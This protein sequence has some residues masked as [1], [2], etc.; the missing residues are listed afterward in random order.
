MEFVQKFDELVAELGPV[1]NVIPTHKPYHANKVLPRK[2]I[3]AVV[4]GN[5]LTRQ[6]DHNSMKRQVEII[7]RAIS[8]PSTTTAEYR[9]DRHSL[10]LHNNRRELGNVINNEASTAKMALSV[11]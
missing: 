2:M 4:G 7:Q 3:K 5:P 10:R 9:R 1:S 8:N 6:Y 11:L